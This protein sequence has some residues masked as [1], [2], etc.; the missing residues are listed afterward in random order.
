M[1]A[2]RA[3]QPSG[4]VHGRAIIHSSLGTCHKTMT[5]T[6][7]Q[8]PSQAG[9]ARAIRPRPLN[10]D[11]RLPVVFLHRRER[12]PGTEPLDPALVEF[13][14]QQEV[15]QQEAQR[16]LEESRKQ[17]RASFA[18]ACARTHMRTGCR[19]DRCRHSR[20]HE[21]PAVTAQDGSA[22]CLVTRNRFIQLKLVTMLRAGQMGSVPPAPTPTCL[23]SSCT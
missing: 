2:A 3:W 1:G 21:R 18:C 14:K 5:T 10:Y 7:Q 23:H 15:E 22:L 8:P 11:E 20:A 17:A 19:R 6:I 9:R 4:E 16:S 13:L 12:E